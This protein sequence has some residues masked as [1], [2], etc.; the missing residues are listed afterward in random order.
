MREPQA[1]PPHLSR[2]KPAETS[3]F[4]LVRRHR[5][6]SR[7]APRLG[8]DLLDFGCGNGAQTLLFA[9]EFTRV[10]GAD[11]D[12]R[13]VAD[14]SR[15]IA[16]GGLEERV[17][18]LRYDGRRLP[19]PDES[20]DAAV[21]FEVLEHVDDDAAALCEVHR[22]LRPDGWLA[23]TVPNRWWLFET[24]G[25]R[26]PLLPWNRV[27]FFSWLPR[28][29]HDRWARARIYR[30]REVVDLVRRAGFEVRLAAYVTAPLDVLRWTWLRDGLRRT[31]FRSDLT[32]WPPQATAILVVA[33][34]RAREPSPPHAQR[35][36]D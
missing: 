10:V 4:I 22:V 34:R 6:V 30:R 32:P 16:A 8:G 26:L 15:R 28:R 33:V 20:F 24:H 14:F 36:D 9:S 31:L 18:A 1:S 35:A 7:H 3:D 27:P 13:H 23:V 19:L 29:L 17:R 12:A 21:S 5:L 25:A 11:V 2:G